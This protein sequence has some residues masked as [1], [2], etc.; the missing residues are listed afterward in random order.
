MADATC[1]D[2]PSVKKTWS[3]S[4]LTSPPETSVRPLPANLGSVADEFQ[5]VTISPSP[6]ERDLQQRNAVECPTV[7]STEPRSPSGNWHPI[8]P[9]NSMTSKNSNSTLSVLS[10]AAAS[11]KDKTQQ[12]AQQQKRALSAFQQKGGLVSWLHGE[13]EDPGSNGSS[14]EQR[15]LATLDVSPFVNTSELCTP[16][17]PCSPVETSL[18]GRRHSVPNLRSNSLLDNFLDKVAAVTTSTPSSPHAHATVEP[19]PTV[20]STKPSVSSSGALTSPKIGRQRAATTD[21]PTSPKTNTITNGSISKAQSSASLSSPLSQPETRFSLDNVLSD[22]WSCSVLWAHLY[23]S[24]A[25]R[26]HQHHQRLSFLIETTFRITPLFQKFAASDESTDKEMDFKKLVTSLKRLHSRFLVQNGVNNGVPVASPAAIQA[27][28]QLSIAIHTLTDQRMPDSEKVDIHVEK[29]ISALLQLAREVERE[30]R[31]LGTRSY[32]NFADSVL[33]RNF[34]AHR[35]GSGN[36]A[37][38]LRAARIPF[39]QQPNA[40]NTVCLELLRAEQNEDPL[41]LFARAGCQVF[42]ITLQP[43][44]SV[45]FTDISPYTSGVVLQQV[46]LHTIAPFLNPST[47]VNPAGSKALAFNFIAGSG[48][49]VIYGAVMWLPVEQS[50]MLGVNDMPSGLCIISKFPLVDSMRHFLCELWSD[51]STN[52][53]VNDRSAQVTKASLAMRTQFFTQPSDQLPVLDFKLDDLFDC[54]SLTNVLRLF[55]FILLEKKI[56]LVASSYTILFCVS[57]ALKALL[58]PLVWS[59]VYVPVLPLGLKDCLHCPTPFIFGLHES[60]VRRSDMPRPSHDLVVVNLDRDSL[61]GGGD[62]FLPPVR[63]TMMR[64][65]LFRLCKP[66]LASRDSVDNFDAG[67]YKLGALPTAAIGRV[68]HKHVREILASLEPC[69]NR[70]EFNGQSV[71]V[72]DNDNSSLWPADTVRF[73]SAMLHTQAVSTYLACSRSDEMEKVERIFM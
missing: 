51:I 44:Y 63:Q 26:D 54:L 35:S 6:I 49:N 46:A 24:A 61:T 60:Y 18:A 21:L 58:H 53:D 12:V 37:L 22:E 57:E 25:G 47:S 16:P 56:V 52:A 73:C 5:S 66:H 19:R 71:S 27:K 43:D 39:Y 7:Q 10:A 11:L 9:S 34:I 2:V 50:N 28:T 32:V 17:S 13:M 3:A 1:A 68:F 30:F 15:P 42:T 29:T 36:I 62:V 38:V 55:A 70:F 45:N 40:E 48:T 59:H 23:S 41:T 69:V 20:A 14:I 64:E 8:S 72:V 4:T 67:K 65:E 31:V 33:Y